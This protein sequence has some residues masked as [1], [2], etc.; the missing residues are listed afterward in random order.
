MNARCLSDALLSL[1]FAHG[2]RLREALVRTLHL[3]SSTWS[4]SCGFLRGSREGL[5]LWGWRC[6]LGGTHTSEGSK[7]RPVVRG[8]ACCP[9]QHLQALSRRAG[10]RPEGIVL[11]Q[12]LAVLPTSP[13]QS[14]NRLSANSGGPDPE[15]FLFAGPESA[16][17]EQPQHNQVLFVL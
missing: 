6:P 2:W 4:S 15:P 7:W 9:H 8:A 10:G 12:S 13:L 11:Q 17:P 1:A 5:G 3:S 14:L 16:G